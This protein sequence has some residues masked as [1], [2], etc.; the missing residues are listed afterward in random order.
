MRGYLGDAFIP[1]MYVALDQNVIGS[2]AIVTSDMDSRPDLSPWLASVFVHSNYRHKGIGARLVKVVMQEA[3]SHGIN[4]LYLFTP[5]Q[6]DFY[7]RLGWHVFKTTVYMGTPV[8][9]MSCRL[10]ELSNDG[11]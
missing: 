3:R 6:T 11:S 5:D 7:K 8:T 1:S 10:Q 9:I 4:T 2:A